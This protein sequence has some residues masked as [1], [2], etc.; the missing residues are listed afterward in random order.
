M[1]SCL[2]F[3][4]E[5]ANSSGFIYDSLL[6]AIYLCLLEVIFSFCILYTLVYILS[7]KII[8]F[9]G[10]ISCDYL[11]CLFVVGFFF[12]FACLDMSRNLV[13]FVVNVIKPEN[14][15]IHFLVTYTSYLHN[16]I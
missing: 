8:L 12:P 10:D 1:Y 4:A 2:T 7:V 9:F 13:A 3:I 15:K 11:V 14:N 16:T 5:C 6:K